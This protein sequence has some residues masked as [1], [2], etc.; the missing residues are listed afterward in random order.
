MDKPWPVN[1]GAYAK[2]VCQVSNAHSASNPS[3]QV[4]ARA[5]IGSTA[6][7]DKIRGIH[8]RAVRRFRDIQR[9]FHCLC[10]LLV[11]R[12]TEFAHRFLIPEISCFSKRVSQVDG[13]RKIKSGGPVVHQGKVWSDMRA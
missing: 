13:V 4:P 11:G 10:E 9:H 2:G 12:D 7:R 1:F 3:S 6:R 8:M 5:D